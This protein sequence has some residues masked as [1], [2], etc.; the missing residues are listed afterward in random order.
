MSSLNNRKECFY[1]TFKVLN[2]VKLFR[3]KSISFKSGSFL[4]RRINEILFAKNE[5]TN[6]LFGEHFNE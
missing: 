6:S 2:L 3:H 1:K 4:R 5:L